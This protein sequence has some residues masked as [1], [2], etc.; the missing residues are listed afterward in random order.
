M[1]G[2]ENLALIK[3]FNIIVFGFTLASS[4][5]AELCSRTKSSSAWLC[6]E[7]NLFLKAFLCF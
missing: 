7:W 5:C 3:R 4:L 6:A 2:R 1:P